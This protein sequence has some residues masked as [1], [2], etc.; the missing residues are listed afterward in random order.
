VHSHLVTVEV[1]LNACRRAVT[2]MALP[3]TAPLER[4]DTQAVERRCT[5]RAPVPLM[6]PS[7]RPRPAGDGAHHA[8]GHL[9]SGPSRCHEPLHD[10]WLEELER[11]ELGQAAL[12]EQS[13][14]RSDDRAARVVD[15]LAEQF[16][17]TPCFP[18]ACPRDLSGRLP[19]GDR[20]PAAVSN[21][22]STASWSIRFSC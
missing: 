22:A 19:A 12:V 2:W 13:S 15:A 16:W 6:T 14:G 3:S 1:A 17:R 18:S 21:S 11:H 20:R 8:L 7:R 9:M 10:E 5:L 4:L